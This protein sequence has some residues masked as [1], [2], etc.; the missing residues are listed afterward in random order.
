MERCSSHRAMTNSLRKSLCES[1]QHTTTMQHMLVIF[2]H[3]Q[4]LQ[5]R[6]SSWKPGKYIA[7]INLFII[8][9]LY[10]LFIFYCLIYL[11][12]L[13][14]CLVLTLMAIVVICLVLC[15]FICPL[16]HHH[17]ALAVRVY[18]PSHP[19]LCFCGLRHVVAISHHG[20]SEGGADVKQLRCKKRTSVKPIRVQIVSNICQWIDQ[21]EDNVR[22]PGFVINWVTLP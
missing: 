21:C 2:I 18:I 16:H 9:Y 4:W 5:S 22:R 19:F 6:W 12:Q 14:N 15:P 11:Y 17:R 8:Y 13:T 1:L 20:A 3:G 7:F 10:L